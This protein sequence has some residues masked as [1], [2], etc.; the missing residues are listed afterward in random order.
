MYLFIT[1]FVY[2]VENSQPLPDQPEVQQNECFPNQPQGPHTGIGSGMMSNCLPTND[3]GMMV[4][5]CPP[6]GMMMGNQIKMGQPVGMMGQ[7]QVMMGQPQGMM[8][9]PQGMMGQPQGMMGQPQG[10]MG[11][12]PGMMGQP[13]GMMGQPQGMVAPDGFSHLPSNHNMPNS[14][15]DMSSAASSG[16]PAHRASGGYPVVNDS[17]ANQ[18][19]SICSN[20]P[21][22]DHKMEVFQESQNSL[23]QSIRGYI[24]QS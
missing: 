14:F 24:F 19:S 13:Q 16:L 22:V 3:T 2:I 5:G 8:G 20:Q 21:V 15:Q 17:T 23:G 7:V 9:Q 10:M 4:P 12:P 18:S 11:Q 6:G 1:N